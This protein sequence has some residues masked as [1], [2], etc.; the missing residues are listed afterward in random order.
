M[1]TISRDIDGGETFNLVIDDDIHLEGKIDGRSALNLVSTTGSITIDGKIDG[2]SSAS[3]TAFG[4]IVI[5][6][7][8]DP[9]GSKCDGRSTL[10]ATSSGGIVELKGKIDGNSNVRVEAR[11]DISIGT[12]GGSGDRK[13]DKDSNVRLTSLDGSVSIGGKIDN[14]CKVEISAGG[15]VSIAT[16][17]GDDERKINND[18]DVR[19]TAGEDIFVDGKI[20]DECRVDFVAC[21]EIEITGDIVRGAAVRLAAQ[22]S[23]IVVAGNVRDNNTS[24]Q[25]WPE[26]ALT[27]E[28]ETDDDTVLETDW[29]GGV[30]PCPGSFDGES[31][32]LFRNWGWSYGF[33][34]SKRIQPQSLAELVAAIQD[35]GA[36]DRVK[37][38]GGAWSFGDAVLP[39]ATQDEVNAV[40]IQ[41]GRG[42]VE[43][44]FRN[45]LMG[46]GGRERLPID[47]RPQTFDQGYRQGRRYNQRALAEEVA[48][49]P[50]MPFASDR[51]S[52]IDTRGLR[53]SLQADMARVLGQDAQAAIENGSHYVW[54]EAGITMANLNV[55]LDHQSPR[56]ALR[57]SG[58]SPGATLAGTIATATHGGEFRW[59]LLVDMV[60][61]I[62]LVGPGGLEWWI[63]GETPIADFEAVHALYP[64]VEQERFITG[65]WEGLDDLTGQDVLNA[66]IVSMG[67][68]GVA[69]SIVLEVVEQYG[70]EQRTVSLGSW[71]RLL[72]LADVRM[73]DLR[74]GDIESNHRVLDFLID[75]AA[76]GS[77]IAATDNVYV[78]LAINP[79]NRACWV[80]N[81][82]VTERLP[83]DPN[84]LPLDFDTYLSTADAMLSRN[85]KTILVADLLADATLGR[86]HDFLSYGTSVLDLAN[87]VDQLSRLIGFVTSRP[88]ILATLLST[89]NVQAVLNE[90]ENR[91]AD[92]G[93]QFLGDILDTV[94]HALQGT[95]EGL[96]STTTG[97]SYE[98]G[99]IGWP[100]GGIPGRGIEVALHRDV[101]FTYL[102][103]TIF[104]AILDPLMNGENNPLIGYISIRVCPATRTLM[105]MQQF[106]PYSVMV[107]VVGLRTIESNVLMDEIQRETLRLNRE[108]GLDGVLHWGLET[109][110]MIADD[111]NHMPVRQPMVSNPG[112][113]RIDA[114]R[115]IRQMF[116]EGQPASFDNNFVRRLNL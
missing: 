101:A 18:C 9:G 50:N 54:V 108:D 87:N 82:R 21:G 25:F 1:H 111:L 59:P 73:D 72:G 93:H 91:P 80:V 40:S 49:G 55:L 39:F 47:L 57:A 68:M 44:D 6:T 56:L 92:R 60:R 2:A 46:R 61:A 32:T 31:G 17:G 69:Y 30:W 110:Q 7:E 71:G 62:H 107:E 65:A 28:G 75:G 34:Y 66:L 81:R 19:A 99:A 26:G 79:I 58:G 52:I 89:I 15:S 103:R 97:V 36:E 12:T 24:V 94:L 14:A 74:D 112:Y 29:I 38:M 96:T 102:Q 83:L 114:W 105:G 104:D 3:L 115:A 98:V 77:G 41:D 43:H 11:G 63:E 113:R 20:S 37:A 78:D 76:N 45:T 8:D 51:Y 64:G 35:L 23:R 86:L 100:E 85:S 5:G 16:E 88:Q 109:D 13:I 95:R 70:L 53:G 84:P 106:E 42:P 67:T 48:P 33:A 10:V 4:D 27:I 116:G 90:I 22:S